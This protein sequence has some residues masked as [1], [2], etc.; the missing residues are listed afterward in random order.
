MAKRK[1]SAGGAALHGGA[2]YQNR[3]AAWIAVEMLAERTA[4]PLT[5]G[6]KVIFLH[7]ETQEDADDILGRYVP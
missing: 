5:T 6:G 1:S 7:G 4:E 2:A 3:V